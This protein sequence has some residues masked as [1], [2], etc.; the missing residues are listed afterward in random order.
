LTPIE[1]PPAR[2]VANSA[3]SL[4]GA[5]INVLIGSGVTIYAVRS[6]D[7]STWGHFATATA[8]VALVTVLSGTGLAPLVLRE[9]ASAPARANEIVG[10]SL[11][12]LGWT[13][14]VAVAVLFAAVVALGYEHEVLVLVAVLSPLVLLA[15]GVAIL[16]S[17]FNARSQLG[18]A[19]W[20]QAPQA[21]LY[22][23]L[24]TAAIAG[25][26]GVT[27]VALATTLS[28]IVAAGLGLVL[29]HRKLG[30]SP[31]LRQPRSE[32]WGLLRAATPFGAIGVIGVVY[33]RVDT[34]MLSVLSSADDVARYVVPYS[35]LRVSWIIPS[36]VSA[37][38]FPLL[39]R[40]IDSAGIEA[41]RLFFLMIRALVF[42]S[43][44]LALF[45][46]LASPDLLPFIFGQRYGESVAVLQIL[47]W[48]LV[49]SFPVY[50]LW[51]GLVARRREREAFFVAVAGLLANVIAN[52]ILIPLY[53][54]SG[55]AAALIVSEIVVVGGYGLLVH[56]HLFRVP[57]RR[58]L[59]KPLGV[60][61]IVVPIAVLVSTQ[62]AA[63]GA[64]G[65]AAAYAG[66]LLALHYV[67]PREWQPVVAI[68]RGPIALLRR[69]FS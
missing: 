28:A 36:V 41:E 18:Y 30:V 64:L 20:F 25:S 13:T 19:A 14:V 33:D 1:D 49:L 27:G 48:T 67:T 39:S 50:V 5:G 3:W 60:G 65:G 15:P 24:A 32:V 31:S 55:A 66:L 53:G 7:T 22:G 44:P 21:I 43:V 45:L 58:L 61:A 9:M 57:L 2:V 38:F 34:L 8:L 11:Q 46:T 37:A 56:R 6:F 4:L 52:G 62:S 17:A 26:L 51:Y 23:V 42:L 40:V 54:P 16:T 68:I 63:G 10:A 35:F 69:V 29:L 12:A 47:A 59:A